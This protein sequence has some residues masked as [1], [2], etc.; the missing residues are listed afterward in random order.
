MTLFSGLCVLFYLVFWG[1]ICVL[2]AI[3]MAVH[4]WLV[5]DANYPERQ[6]WGNLLKNNPGICIKI[7]L[8]QN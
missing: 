6:G 8:T 4:L 5:V 3:V 2:F 7:Y 1:M